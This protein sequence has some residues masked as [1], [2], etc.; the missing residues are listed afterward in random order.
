MKNK[1]LLLISITLSV[2]LFLFQS[3]STVKY[4]SQGEDDQQATTLIQ[5]INYEPQQEYKKLLAKNKITLSFTA[6]YNNLGTLAFYFNNYQKI[7]SD[8]VWFRIKDKNAPNWYYQNKYNTDQF[9]PEY[10][11]T[12][13]FPVI[14]DSKNHE[15]IVEIE[16]ISGTKNNSISLHQKSDNFRAKYSFS[17]SYLSQ[18]PKQ[19]TPFILNKIKTYLSY[20][21]KNDIKNILL[22]SSLPLLIY[23]LII[24]KPLRL[25]K[26]SKYL[27]NLENNQ[28]FNKFSNYFIPIFI[29]L[30]TL[31]IAGYFSTIEA[32]PHHD[33]ILFKPAI[34]VMSGQTLF[35]D[36]FT[37][38]GALT[39][40]IQAFSLKIFGPYLLT[41][42]FLTVFFYGLISL[43]LFQIFKR[44]LPK[45]ILFI[46][47][48]I[49]I[50]MAPYYSMTFL[51]W[52]SVY[53]LFFQ[54]LALYLLIIF[55]E[56]KSLKYFILASISANLVFWCRQPVGIFL[57]LAICS[58]FIY[59][60]LIKQ[61]NFK[62]FDKY[63]SHFIFT[64]FVT[65]L[66]FISYF[67]LNHSLVDWFKQSILLTLFWGQ[68]VADGFS[69]SKI[70]FTL[71]PIS[72]SPVS[73]WVLIPISTILLFI[74]NYKNKVLL[75]PI[76]IGLASW[77]QYY[78]VDCIRHQYWSATP[79]IPLFSLFIYQTCQKLIFT[80]YK[81][82][83]NII[84][85]FS[86]ILIIICFTPD[87][88]YRIKEGI[89]KY[90]TQYEYVQEPS[91]LKG[92][93]LPSEEAKFYQY[94]S[95]TFNQYFD[96]NPQGNIITNGPNPLY[97]TF[98]NRIKNI[99]AL[100]V[101]WSQ[102]TNPIYPNYSNIFSKNIESKESLLISF[103]DQIPSGYCRI[104]KMINYDS[105]A[106]SAPCK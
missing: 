26:Q 31:V 83:K 82:S 94:M 62:T 53:A 40:F 29:F 92:I 70:L 43:L 32:D 76:F 66:L 73:I 52:S 93:K 1:V 30:L 72:I 91:V 49:W 79:I 12:F 21:P 15:Y 98:D 50:F 16:S 8:W 80:D 69:L 17:K 59:L 39:T 55:F 47:L 81:L 105:A 14:P 41:I 25:F 65:T 6:K 7:N 22:K 2:I 90:K 67:I 71:F 85:Y 51:P 24:S 61:I 102:V 23:L 96:N 44:F 37:Q 64:N 4:R 28:T 100:Y 38:Y 101:N 54:L 45:L 27:E 13:G 78:P 74:T 88:V 34:D 20:V 11:S 46:S 86:V 84:K 33:G 35:K 99:Q 48:L 60:Y 75:L 3:Y 87:I 9:N 57:F 95:K 89:K 10:Y 97:L 42:K 103:W 5:K 77:L 68:S 104:D 19:I 56:K 58:Y 18:N 106:I 63:I 36:T